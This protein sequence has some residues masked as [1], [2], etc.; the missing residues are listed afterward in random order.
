MGTG[1]EIGSFSQPFFC[2]KS[3]AVENRREIIKKEN[4]KNHHRPALGLQSLDCARDELV[5][6]RPTLG[7]RGDFEKKMQSQPLVPIRSIR[8]SPGPQA[9]AMPFRS[10]VRSRGPA[11]SKFSGAKP[12]LDKIKNQNHYNPRPSLD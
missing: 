8:A 10:D 4:P 9:A 11:A 3:S 2:R 5:G 6:E 7:P 12:V 1:N